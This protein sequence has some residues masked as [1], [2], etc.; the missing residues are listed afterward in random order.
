MNAAIWPRPGPQNERLLVIDPDQGILKDAFI[1]DLPAAL[2]SSDL[3][4]INDAA[5]LPASMVG[6]LGMESQD[7]EV[8]I[9]LAAWV[10]DDRYQAVVFGEGTWRNDTDSRPS[11][12]RL[13]PGQAITFDKG[14]VAWV[15]AISS[16]SPRL[17]TLRFNHSGAAL[18]QRFF[19]VG[20]PVQYSYLAAPLSVQQVQTAFA[21]RP[22]SMEMPSAGRP[23]RHGLL[24]RLRSRG[25][26]VAT[27]TH[28][29]GLSATGD[30]ALDAALPL[31]EPYWIPPETL[32][33]IAEA[34]GRGGR[35]VAVGTTVVRA[36][37][38]AWLNGGGKISAGF[39]ITALK[40]TDGHRLQVVDGIFTGMHD[41]SESHF[42]LLGA[43]A[44]REVL[45]SAFDHATEAGY[46][47]HE[48][49]DSGLILAPRP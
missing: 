4:V 29:A 48:F 33:A 46:L 22:V 32:E 3:L 1:R 5:T 9:R 24:A 42:E 43:F 14:L 39:G 10:D 15:D 40:I 2:T 19:E 34:Q 41:P 30:A 45:E 23:L 28:G 11:P 17:C 49:G 21:G 36:L 27:L 20:R 38:G 6:R 25:V 12:P 18:I 7:R 44:S 8:E 35:V 16:I 37:E 47:G 26:K 13:H 31:P